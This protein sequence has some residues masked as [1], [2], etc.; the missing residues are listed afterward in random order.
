M[1]LWKVS[2]EM[3]ERIIKAMYMKY[4]E[5]QDCRDVYMVWCGAVYIV[6]VVLCVLWWVEYGVFCSEFCGFNF[7]FFCFLFC[8]FYSF[9]QFDFFCFVM[10]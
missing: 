10:R 6:S 5:K 7:V 8:F 2:L 3:Y 4:G 9:F 1:E